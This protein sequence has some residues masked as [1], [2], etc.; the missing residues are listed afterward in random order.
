MEKYFYEIPES[1]TEYLPNVCARINLLFNQTLKDFIKRF[2]KL[3]VMKNKNKPDREY[4][5]LN[6]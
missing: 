4:I 3:F 1:D 6:I 5:I 2:G